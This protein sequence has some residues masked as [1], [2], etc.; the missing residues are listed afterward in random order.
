[1]WRLLSVLCLALIVCAP[2][3]YVWRLGHYDA[4]FSAGAIDKDAWVLG[5]S[6]VPLEAGG[7]A[8]CGIAGLILTRRR[9]QIQR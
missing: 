3:R 5:K 1:M 9:K 4:Q 7:V 6:A 2:A 8:L